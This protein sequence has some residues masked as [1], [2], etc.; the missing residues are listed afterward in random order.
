MMAKWDELHRKEQAKYLELEQT[1]DDRR[2][3]E[4]LNED[5]ENFASF[6]NYLTDDYDYWQGRES[7]R[8][9]HIFEEA[10][11]LDRHY[12]NNA[13]NDIDFSIQQLKRQERDIEEN[14]TVLRLEKNKVLWEEEEKKYGR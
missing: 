5:M 14:I 12:T 4:A 6:S 2:A 13:F 11:D 3:V 7:S 9:R 10:F 1:E 8:Y